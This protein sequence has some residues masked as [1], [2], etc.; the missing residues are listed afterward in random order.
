VKAARVDVGGEEFVLV[1][2]DLPRPR[3]SGLSPAEAEVAELVLQGC[4]NAEIAG[5]RCSTVGTVAKQIARVFTK[6]GVRSRS[7]LWAA[8]ARASRP[9]EL[10]PCS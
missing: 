7:E 3:I 10:D 2:W 4:S 8:T 6:L 9:E 1:E 5:T